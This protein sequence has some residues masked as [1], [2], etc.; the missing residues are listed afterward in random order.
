M[1]LKNKGIAK[2]G[3]YGMGDQIISVLV[4]TPTKLSSEQKDIFKQL[5]ELEESNS[6]CNPMSKGFF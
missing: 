6:D 5:H 4:E 2:L 3:G 1:R